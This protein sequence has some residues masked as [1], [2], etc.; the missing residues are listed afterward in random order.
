MRSSDAPPGPIASAAAAT[1]PGRPDPAAAFI[2]SAIGW[3]LASTAAFGLLA[4]FSLT[5]EKIRLLEDPTYVPACTIDAVLSCGSVM[6]SPQAEAFGFPN[7]LLGIAGF[8]ALTA[9]G[10][11]LLARANFPRWLWLAMQL[12]LTFAVVFV[13]WLFF[14]SVYR[15]E[16]LCPYCMV[17]WVATIVAF[18]YL[19]LH[20]LAQRNLPSPSPLR[21]AI[22]AATRYHGVILSAWLAILTLLI[23]EAFWE[24]WRTVF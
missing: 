21:P 16:A 24:H 8:A 15:I 20:N 22:A 3:I 9:L 19:T 14:Q 4:A 11:A 12:G 5:V 13:H 1:D 7:P 2:A 23:V 10:V 18:L 6:S 17:V